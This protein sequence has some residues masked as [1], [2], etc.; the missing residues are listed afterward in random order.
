MNETTILE[1]NLLALSARNSE[2]SAC[3]SRIEPSDK[4]KYQFSRTGKLVPSIIHKG[5]EHPLHSLFD[6]VQEGIKYSNLHQT[7]GYLVFIGFGFAYHIMPFLERDDI[8]NILIIEKDLSLFKNTLSKTD[9]SHFILDPR[10][11]FLVDYTPDEIKEYLLSNYLPAKTGNLQILYLRKKM[12]TQED[13]FMFVV[14]AIKE[15]LSTLADDYTVQSC[16]GKKWF[17]NTLSNL[18]AA[19]HSHTILKPIRKA[20]V[21]AAGPSLEIQ[22]NELKAIRDKCFLIATDTSLPSILKYSII[23]DLVISIDCQHITYHHFLS[24]YPENVPLLLDLASPSSLTKLTKN[25]IFFTSGHPFSQY[26]NT[27]WRK[28]PCID[29]SGGNVTHAAISLADTLGAQEIYLFGAD[30][31][32]PEGKSYARGTYLYPYFRTKALKTMPLEG[33][34]FSFLFR[35]INMF[36]ETSNDTIR[37]TTRPMIS[38]KKR[39][40]LASEKINAKIIPIPGKGIPLIMNPKIMQKNKS[41]N[42]RTVFSA[43]SPTGNWDDFLLDYKKRLLSLPEPE[44]PMAQYLSQLNPGEKDLWITLYPAAA[45]FRRENNT[46]QFSGS[47]ILKYVRE[48]SISILER[49]I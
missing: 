24:G 32:Y 19:Q 10:I 20:I 15:V 40:E 13:Y 26:V 1:R 33:Q 38:Y 31:S 7:G 6:P 41:Q 22:I 21:T 14:K 37:Y 47:E 2:L 29:I 11:Y 45:A 49:Y 23:P 3:I 30:Y 35:N 4:I 5:H 43:G 8:S 48:W 17:I 27:Y 42:I 18:K 28:F 12:Q 16:F 25:L 46:F 39:L 44:E 34:F 9:F 36:K